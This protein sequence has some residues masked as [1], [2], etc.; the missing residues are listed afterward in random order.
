MRD[1]LRTFNYKFQ[2]QISVRLLPLLVLISFVAFGQKVDS[3]SNALASADHDTTRLKV[4]DAI[5]ENQSDDYTAIEKYSTQMRDLSEP[6]LATS[7]GKDKSFYA[8]YYGT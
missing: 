2:I 6:H 7:S 3:L 5:I 4:L 8:H 1:L